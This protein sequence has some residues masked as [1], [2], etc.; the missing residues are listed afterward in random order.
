[1]KT[2]KKLQ[3]LRA[4]RRHVFYDF[5]DAASVL[6]CAR[7]HNTRRRR[8]LA[9]LA[10][11]VS[12]GNETSK[13]FGRLFGAEILENAARHCIQFVNSGGT[14]KAYSAWSGIRLRHL[15]RAIR[16]VECLLPVKWSAS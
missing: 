4:I 12:S 9:L 7:R 10:W 1:M 2:P 13:E 14:L 6:V 15:S 5:E 3:Q 8:R 11:S 16:Q